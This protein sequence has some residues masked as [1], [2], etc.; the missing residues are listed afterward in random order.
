MLRE[1]GRLPEARDARREVEELA[2][3]AQ[4][5]NR[6]LTAVQLATMA[7]L[8]ADGAAAARHLT[9]ADRDAERHG[10]TT[11]A[12]RATIL[13]IAAGALAAGAAPAG[14]DDAF[15][16]GGRHGTMA[17]TSPYRLLLAEAWGRSSDHERARGG[18]G[19]CVRGDDW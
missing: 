16:V 18:G 8:R 4:P 10:F 15:E 17:S 7:L 2:A 19:A 12:I 14:V 3:R 9:V 11:L 6:C 1:L 13:R 5:F